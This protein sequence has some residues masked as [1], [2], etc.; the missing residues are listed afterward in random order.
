MV[1]S[2]VKTVSKNR[3]DAMNLCGDIA[4]RDTGYF[5]NRCGVNALEIEKNNLPV[6]WIESLNQIVK[7]VE[8][9]G[10]IE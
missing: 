1:S 8:D 9:L 10:L 3:L 2:V 4:G 7:A 6:K 5:A